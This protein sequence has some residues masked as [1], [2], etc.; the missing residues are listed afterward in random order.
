MIKSLLFAD[1]PA[2]SPVALTTAASLDART[3]SKAAAAV[4]AVALVAVATHWLWP[5]PDVS[6][7]PAAATT[8]VAM[9]QPSKG[10][11]DFVREANKIGQTT[12]D[13]KEWAF[14]GY[15]GVAF[16]YPSTVAIKN[17][18]TTD[19]TA[20]GFDWIG[21]PF[22][23][24]IYY[25]ARIQRWGDGRFGGM[26]DFIHAK[27]IAKPDST[28]QLTGAHKGKPLPTEAPIGDIFSK[29]EFSHGHNMLTLNG[30]LRLVPS[31]FRFRPYLGAGAGVSLPHTE[32]GF[33]ED[34]VRTYE[35]QF[36]G[37]VGQGLGGLEVQLGRVS[38]F[39]EYKF[40]YAPYNVPLSHEPRGDILVTDL[41]R[42]FQAWWKGE[43]PPGGRLTTTLITHHGVAGVLVKNGTVVDPAR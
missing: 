20:S 3:L 4:Q 29:L 15:G 37:F 35:Y 33:R 1:R 38:V 22:K 13:A 34:N 39:F 16:T 43:T 31:W 41:W 8:P 18:E 9:A 24:P 5:A 42:Q 2:Y 28:A 17:G 11:A 27:A 14:G 32:V 26:L 6:G 23:A 36:A 12:R 19:M 30:M 10:K 21:M 40:T 7:T 25:G